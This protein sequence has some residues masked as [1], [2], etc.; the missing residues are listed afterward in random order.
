MGNWREFAKEVGIIVLGVLIAL[1]AEQTVEAIH[2]R[3][4]VRETRE[5]LRQEMGHNLTSLQQTL[6][7]RLCAMARLDEVER[8]KN[9]WEDGHPLKLTGPIRIPPYVIFGTSTWK[10]TAGDAVARMPLKDRTAYAQI[11]AGVD[12][13]DRLREKMTDAWIELENLSQA[14]RL[15]DDQLLKIDNDVQGIRALYDVLDSNQQVELS[16]SKELG[17]L[18][19]KEDPLT[20]WYSEQAALACKPL[21]AS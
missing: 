4:E 9:S 6:D 3:S 15:S 14:R 20:P 5:A 18:P 1:G 2:H 19:A 16:K 21:L 11:Y 17:I 10:V 13:N 12:N 7:R 8:W